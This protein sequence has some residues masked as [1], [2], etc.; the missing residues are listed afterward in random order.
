MISVLVERKMRMKSR[1]Q[2]I[3]DVFA[4]QSIIGYEATI[5]GDKNEPAEVLF[6]KAHK[7]GA[8]TEL[9][10]QAR[11]MA[12]Q[13]GMPGLKR[14]QLLFVNLSSYDLNFPE[15]TDF[16]KLVIEITEHLEITEAFAERLRELRARGAQIAIDDFGKAHSNFKSFTQLP[17]SFLKMDKFFLRDL[18]PGSSSASVIR[19]MVAMCQERGIK[20]IV[21]GVERVEQKEALLNLNVRYMQG[22]YFGYPTARLLDTRHIQRGV[23]PV[24]SASRM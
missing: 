24:S 2:P 16:H 5:R 17:I 14:N 9:D 10:K 4:N 8:V 15:N 13:Y 19:S 11:E 22:F 12:I 3:V 7:A 6:D 23:T 20:V 1:F 18:S 21:E